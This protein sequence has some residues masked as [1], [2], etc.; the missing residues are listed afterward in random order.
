MRL[1][2]LRANP[3]FLAPTLM[4][5]LMIF[6]INDQNDESKDQLNEEQSQGNSHGLRGDLDISC[7]EIDAANTL[8]EL[9]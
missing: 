9:V 2:V 3:F 1:L 7:D 4:S 6:P 8:I 5:A